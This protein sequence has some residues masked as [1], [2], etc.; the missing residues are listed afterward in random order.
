MHQMRAAWCQRIGMNRPSLMHQWFLG[1][2]SGALVALRS[3]TLHIVS[4]CTKQDSYYAGL[5]SF[6]NAGPRCAFFLMQ[7]SLVACFQFVD[8]LLVFSRNL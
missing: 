4:K 6:A 2:T 5:S 7:L 3:S 8:V 1:H